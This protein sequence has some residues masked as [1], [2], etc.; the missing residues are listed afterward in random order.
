MVARTWQSNLQ[1]T[2]PLLFDRSLVLVVNLSSSFLR[3]TDP[4]AL[5]QQHLRYG[6]FAFLNP[7]EI[8]GEI[9]P[10]ASVHA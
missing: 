4:M 10:N 9:F 8:Y 7:Q 2:L 1:A 3:K 5:I 6:P